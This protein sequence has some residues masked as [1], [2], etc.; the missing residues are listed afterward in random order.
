MN[1]IQS[2]IAY[3]V[4]ITQQFKRLHI[5]RWYMLTNNVCHHDDNIWFG[6]HKNI[7]NHLDARSIFNIQNLIKSF[8]TS[9]ILR[10]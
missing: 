8:I 3:N 9:P 10:S 2:E 7:V 4:Y 6:H 5:N 1:K